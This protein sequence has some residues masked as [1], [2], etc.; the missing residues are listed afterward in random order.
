MTEIVEH[1]KKNKRQIL[2]VIQYLNS[3]HNRA[4]KKATKFNE[5]TLDNIISKLLLPLWVSVLEVE[6]NIL[7]FESTNYTE[8]FLDCTNLASLSECDRWTNLTTYFFKEQYLKGNQKREITETTIGDTNYHRYCTLTELINND[9]KPYIELRNRI[10]HGQW[11]V[12]FNISSTDTNQKITQ[13]AWTL[14]K[15]DLILLKAFIE[16]LPKLLK[17]LIVS[18]R[19][20]ERDYDRYMNRIN[21]AKKDVDIRLAWIL[22]ESRK[23]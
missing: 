2:L 9:L 18:K 5:L 22:K 16:N 7:L 19:T 6:L 10:A 21:L 8:K 3:I 20:F 17:Q 12:A 13:K 14:S 11:A 1:W 15:K 4:L 23:R